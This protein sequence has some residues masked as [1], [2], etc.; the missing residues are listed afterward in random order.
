VARPG[1][2]EPQ[3]AT[4]VDTVPEGK[5]WLHEV[6]FDGYR[7]ECVVDG[8]TARLFTRKGNDWTARFPGVASAAAALRA[9]QAILDGEV[10]ALLPDG[11]SSF[12]LLQERLGADPP[13]A[14]VYYVFDVLQAD[15]TNLRPLP[16]EERKKRLLSIVGTRA[17]RS[18]VIRYSDH[19]RGDS[20]TVLSEACGLG[21]EGVVSKRGDAPY[22]S[23]RTRTWLKIKCLN[24]QEFVVV[25]F[26]EPK[27]GRIGIGALLLGVRNPRGKLRY[28]GRVGTGMS[29]AMLGALRARL[30][31]LLRTAPAVE[32]AP[33]RSAAGVHWVEPRLVVEV[34]FTEWTRDGILRH[35]ALVGMR[36]DKSP[37]EVRRE[38]PMNV[39]GIVLTNADRVLYPEQGLT[40]HDLAAYYDAIAPLM[41]PH[42]GGRPL[43]LVRCPEGTAKACFF[44]KHWAKQLPEAVQ[45]VDIREANGAKKPYTVVEDAAGLVSLVQHGVL[46]FHLWGASADNVEAPDRIVFDL[47]PAPEVPWKRVR[48]GARALRQIL[49][50]LG[51]ESWIKTTGGKGLHVVVPIARRS[52]W[53]DVS[54]FARALA[55]HMEAEQPARYLAKASKAARKGKVFVDWLRNTR[56]ATWVAPWSTRARPNAPIS[57]PI[58]WE[59][60][61]GLKSGD[62][63]RVSQLASLL[64]KRRKNP[65]EGMLESRQRL[66]RAMTA[67]LE[68]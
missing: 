30:E 61:D 32:A 19:T 27:G 49:E 41:L 7:I 67:K 68:E 40:K 42:V 44:Q 47:D 66:T 29:D 55:Y 62:Q 21:L 39:A 48:E 56:G 1:F 59:E 28:A 25:G 14:M 38:D 9:G 60:L 17:R 33:A 34:A 18:G 65:W 3:L 45:T 50:G 10:V 54:A 20:A 37:R 58:A 24:R 2:I 26:T 53:D 52:T 5:E 43:S 64:S 12:Q 22:Q 15:G 31:T 63:F 4:L 46:E 16:L 51:L 35:P 36:E 8:G 13:G 57:V 6:K 11:R 23:G